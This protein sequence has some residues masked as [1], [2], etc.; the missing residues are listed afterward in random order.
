M[1]QNRLFRALNEDWLNQKLFKTISLWTPSR[2]VFPKF[3]KVVSAIAGIDLK[4]Y[5][6]GYRPD[7]TK[8]SQLKINEYLFTEPKKSEKT[9]I[10]GV[11]ESRIYKDDLSRSDAQPASRFLQP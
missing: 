10:Q 1:Q 8:S 6:V 3:Q 11:G 9:P 7:R 4:S 2:T 5:H